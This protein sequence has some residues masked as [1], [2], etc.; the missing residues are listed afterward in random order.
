MA[1]AN[2][3]CI[4]YEQFIRR[5][6]IKPLPI[7]IV[8]MEPLDLRAHYLL[9]TAKLPST[10]FCLKKISTSRVY[11]VFYL[12]FFFYEPASDSLFGKIFRDRFSIF[13]ILTKHLGNTN[14]Y[15]LLAY[16]LRYSYFYRFL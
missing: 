1:I 14:C 11:R 6:T 15:V 12:F 2:S 13:L 8:A 3:H 9:R 16:T 4:Q 10:R 5:K 7:I